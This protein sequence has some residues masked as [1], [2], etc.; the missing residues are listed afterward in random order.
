[1]LL[2]FNYTTNAIKHHDRYDSDS[3]ADEL[4]IPVTTHSTP[5]RPVAI[6]PPPFIEKIILTDEILTETFVDTLIDQPPIDEEYTTSSNHK[7]PV[8]PKPPLPKDDNT[9]DV[10]F[11]IVEHMPHTMTCIEMNTAEERYH[12]TKKQL[13]GYFSRHLSY[14]SIAKDN[15]ISGTVVLQFN[16]SKSGLVEHVEVI[17]DIGG[18]CGK[19]TLRVFK[20]FLSENKGWVPGKQRGRAVDVRMTLPIKFQLNE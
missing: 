10:P 5:V 1:M 14:P 12:C 13:L 11:L 4:E 9:D 6:V 2:V 3:P 20:D 18:G 7:S 19:E 16:I 17:R 8:V 15:E